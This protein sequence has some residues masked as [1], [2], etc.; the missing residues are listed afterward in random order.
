MG[1]CRQR[2][3]W[4]ACAVLGKGDLF[5]SYDW[6]ELFCVLIKVLSF[7]GPL[8]F[9]ILLDEWGGGWGDSGPDCLALSHA[10]VSRWVYSISSTR[11][12]SNGSLDRSTF[13]LRH[14]LFPYSLS[15][16]PTPPHPTTTTVYSLAV[17]VCV[18][19]L[20]CISF[21]LSSSSRLLFLP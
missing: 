17:C 4:C 19:R 20:D 7:L 3:L 18:Y 16:P 21:E 6:S 10:L 5:R 12:L 1:S 9:M 14:F 8:F 13:M 2:A 11:L 15:C